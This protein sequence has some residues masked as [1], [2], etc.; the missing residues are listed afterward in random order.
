MSQQLINR[1]PDLKQLRDEGYD[2]EV[3]SG[4]LLVKSVP[5]VNSKRE[6]RRGTLVTPL[7]DVSGDV[8]R[9]P[10]D[11]AAYFIGDHPCRPD[12]SFIEQIKHSS[13]T[14]TL[15]RGVVVNHMFSAKPKPAGRYRDYHHKMVTYVGLVSSP[16]RSIDSTAMPKHA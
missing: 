8:T 7:G 15:A 13:E 14:K 10:S 11:H 9:Q 12:G 4:H 16:A 5:Y 3:R 6:V 2:I 1:S